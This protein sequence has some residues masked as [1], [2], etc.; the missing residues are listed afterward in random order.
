MTKFIFNKNF[1]NFDE[2][3]EYTYSNKE[4]KRE[5]GVLKLIERFKKNYLILTSVIYL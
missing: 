4:I 5:G 1:D 3:V 2:E